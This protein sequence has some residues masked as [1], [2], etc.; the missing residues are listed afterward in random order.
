VK[1][2]TYSLP[3]V[4]VPGGWDAGNYT[5]RFT[6]NGGYLRY[7]GTLI[8]IGFNADDCKIEADRHRGINRPAWRP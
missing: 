3:W 1:A 5:I 4:E 2:G 7:R 6:P 8:H